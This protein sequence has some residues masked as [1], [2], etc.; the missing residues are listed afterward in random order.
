MLF[1][2]SGLKKLFVIG[3]AD[4][5]ETVAKTWGKEPSR[6]ITFHTSAGYIEGEPEFIEL[7]K[8]TD[9]EI[10]ESLNQIQSEGKRVG[11]YEF[12]YISLDNNEQLLNA[13]YESDILTLKN[14]TIYDEKLLNK[15]NI[16][17]YTIFLNQVIGIIPGK[18]KKE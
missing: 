4:A 7:I 3:V 16:N 2:K 8:G 17:T 13:D 9:E 15:V 10:K 18:M 14:V 1:M 5:V 12:A 11:V 6:I